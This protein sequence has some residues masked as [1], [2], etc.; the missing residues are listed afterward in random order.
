M[1][2]VY[3]IDLYFTARKTIT[4]SA[5]TR[6]EALDRIWENMDLPDDVRLKDVDVVDI[7][8]EPHYEYD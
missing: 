7:E 5:P 1:D 6:E 4:V 8:E 2:K 3:T